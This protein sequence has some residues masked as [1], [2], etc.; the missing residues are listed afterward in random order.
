MVSGMFVGQQDYVADYAG[1]RRNHDEDVSAAELFCG[2][3][4]DDGESG[5]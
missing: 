3:G 4:V 2:N 5:C 1:E